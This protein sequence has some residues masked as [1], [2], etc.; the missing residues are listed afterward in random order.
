MRGKS[1]TPKNAP[2]ERE[3]VRLRMDELTMYEQN[4]KRHP[5]EQVKQIAKSIKKFGDNVPIGIWGEKNIIVDGHGRYLAKK[6]LGDEYANC[7]RLDHMTDNERRAY[8]LAVNKIALN[9]GLDSRV[10][11]LELQ[12]IVSINMS[13]F[14]FKPPEPDT[15][16]YGDARERTDNEYN[17]RY[18][19]ATE[20]S[21]TWQIPTLERCNHVP[22]DLIGF[23]YA[24]SSTDERAGVHFFIDDY[25]FER[26]WKH[27]EKYTKIL[28]RFDCVLTPDFSLYMDM[29]RCMKLWNIYRSRLIGQIW[30]DAGMKVI[31]TMSWAETETFEFC[32]EGIPQGSTV[33]VSTV[34]V[35]RDK[36][37]R[38]IWRQGTDEMMRRIQ[39]QTVILYGKAIDYDWGKSKVVSYQPKAFAQ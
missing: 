27:P 12:S 26:V 3:I 6:M 31:P 32:F 4:A 25:Q 33:A 17:L 2:Q 15:G 29:P 28:S 30:Q 37:A 38:E 21:G 20:S 13:D 23:N 9:S 16:Y 14:G 18:F 5:P 11:Q 39:P 19:H 10:T 34:G 8:T 22:R 7:V 1:D 24:L 35:L 36:T